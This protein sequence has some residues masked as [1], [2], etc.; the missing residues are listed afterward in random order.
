[1]E[2]FEKWWENSGFQEKTL[3]YVDSQDAAYWAWKAALESMIE[4]VIV[5][6]TNTKISFEESLTRFIYE[7][8]G[9]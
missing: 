5:S 8:L 3:P 2:E 4:L 7:E 9:E 6:K 1:M